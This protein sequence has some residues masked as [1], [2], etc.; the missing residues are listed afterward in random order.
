VSIPTIR[1][2]EKQYRETDNLEKKPLSRNPKKLPPEKLKDYLK[3]PP[4]AYQSEVAEAFGCTATA[5]RKAYNGL[6]V[7]RKKDKALP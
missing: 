7:T 2:W 3:G 6:G 1:Q 5:I 4:D